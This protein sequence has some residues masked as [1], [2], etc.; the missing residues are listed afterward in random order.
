MTRGTCIRIYN[1][2]GPNE[3]SRRF[4][5]T[6]IREKKVTIPD[7]R[8]FDFFHVEDLFRVIELVINGTIQDKL[9]D[10]VYSKKYKLSE[11]AR[12][13]GA[14]PVITG[15][16]DIDYVGDGSTIEFM[17]FPELDSILKNYSNK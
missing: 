9:F 6:C 7:D 4:I 10:A 13:I 5:S 8:Y 1:C 15:T 14:E 16:S 12:M 3:S 2:F 17:Q 11:V